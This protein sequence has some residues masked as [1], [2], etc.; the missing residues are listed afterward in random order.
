[1]KKRELLLVKLCALGDVIRTTCLLAPLRAKHGPCRV[2]WVTAPEA[3]DLLKGLGIEKVLP[4]GPKTSAYLKDR[5]FDVV[6]NLDEDKAACEAASLPKAARL[7]GGYLDAAGKPAYTPDSADYFDMGLLNRGADGTLSKANALKQANRKTYQQ[8][9]AEV[10]GLDLAGYPR[11]Y[12]PAL[13]LSVG[14]KAAAAKLLAAGGK[15]RVGVN[16]GS[17]PRWTAKQPSV[18]HAAEIVKRLTAKGFEVVLFGG[19][20][21]RQR[22][23]EIAKL[24]GAG[25]DPGVHNL[26][27]FAALIARCKALVTTDSLALHFACATG[28]PCVVLFGPTSP[29]EIE[30]YKRGIKLVPKPAC[31]CYYQSQCSA[32]L[33]CVDSI[34]ASAVVSAVELLLG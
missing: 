14:Q 26:K 22:N 2:T 12:E 7:I 17:G 4:V 24:A 10:L 1:M 27:T 31:S 15:P 32:A 34:P 8:L 33:H 6:L 20:L 25:I 11:G 9:W 23:K 28:T 19:D 29:D 18:E 16:L 13:A 30:L 21:E 5:G 3:V